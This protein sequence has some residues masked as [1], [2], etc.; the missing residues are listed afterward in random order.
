M[1]RI[2]KLFLFFFFLNAM[3]CYAQVWDPH[4]ASTNFKGSEISISD[5]TDESTIFMINFQPFFLEQL[6]RGRNPWISF[7]SHTVLRCTNPST[8]KK[9]ALPIKQLYVL[10]GDNYTRKKAYFDMKYDGNIILEMKASP[11]FILE[12]PP[13][14]FQVDLVSIDENEGRRSF[15]WKDIEI[16]QRVQGSI[17]NFG[18]IDDLE[19][20]LSQSTFSF[21]GHYQEIGG[22]N[23]SIIVVNR[24]DTCFLISEK[25]SNNPKRKI[26]DIYGWGVPVSKQGYFHGKWL[27]EYNRASDAWFEIDNGNIGIKLELDKDYVAQFVLMGGQRKSTENPK[28]ATWSGTGFFIS[29]DGYIITNNHVIDGAKSIRVTS[30]NGDMNNTYKAQIEV[31]DKQ[32]DLAIIKISETFP[33]IQ[34]LPYSFKFETSNIGEDCWVLGY[35]LTSSMGNDIKLTNGI[36]SSKS[37]FEGNIAQYQISAPVQPGNSGG[38]VFDKSGQ[39]IGVVQ[40]KHLEAENASYAIKMNY[41][42]NLIDMLPQPIF[43]SSSNPLAQKP[44]SVQ[45]KLASQTVVLIICE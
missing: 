26:G 35:P 19:Y 31:A 27:N 7:G 9:I 34:S 41:V 6:S 39:I 3:C 2:L 40:A 14:P 4:V 21:C 8:G 1:V 42:K 32:N 45:G 28:S 17:P 10:S 11:F 13:I 30:I 12:F 24:N 29:K 33:T 22:N 25:P 38:P 5:A 16:K 20:M 23:S 43:L 18:G 44:L 37:G 36:I 15:Y